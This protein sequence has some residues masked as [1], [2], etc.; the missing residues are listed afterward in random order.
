MEREID[1]TQPPIL[2]PRSI[3]HGDAIS[4][5]NIHGYRTA[6]VLIGDIKCAAIRTDRSHK[7]HVAL[8]TKGPNTITS[9]K[10]SNRSHTWHRP[11]RQACPLSINNPISSIPPIWW[12]VVPK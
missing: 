1:K 9:R 2:K 3:D 10:D 6:I 12:Q 7:R 5:T 8:W 11:H 4:F